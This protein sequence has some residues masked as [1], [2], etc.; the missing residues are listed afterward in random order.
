MNGDAGTSKNVQDFKILT[1]KRQMFYYP[2]LWEK[3]SLV[4]SSIS[5]MKYDFS[6]IYMLLVILKN[7][8]VLYNFQEKVFGG[9]SR[10]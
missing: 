7:Y 5:R 8:L 4:C 6:G 9:L 3:V 10:S 2:F 1:K